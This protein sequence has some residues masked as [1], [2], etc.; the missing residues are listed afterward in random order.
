MFG[1]ASSKQTAPQQRL[2]QHKGS[3]CCK[4]LSSTHGLASHENAH[5]TKDDR[6]ITKW[7]KF[8]KVKLNNLPGA[9]TTA[10]KEDNGEHNEDYCEIVDSTDDDAPAVLHNA[11]LPSDHNL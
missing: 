11:M 4:F 5:K 9:G 3:F 6:M 10:H 1:A 8:G 7:P 2:G